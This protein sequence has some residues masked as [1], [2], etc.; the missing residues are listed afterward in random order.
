M[1]LELTLECSNRDVHRRSLRTYSQSRQ[2]R[3]PESLPHGI[4]LLR[5]TVRRAI[6]SSRTKLIS[7]RSRCLISLWETHF[8]LSLRTD[9]LALLSERDEYTSG[10]SS[11]SVHLASKSATKVDLTY[12]RICRGRRSR[13]VLRRRRV[14]SRR[15]ARTHHL[16]G[17]LRRAQESFTAHGSLY[18][19][20]NPVPGQSELS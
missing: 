15:R 8:D 6:F 5:S 1:R 17:P 3:S 9:Y 18:R 19:G 7:A 4:H 11:L 13:S 14:R 16:Q 10:A 20:G 2:L 12:L